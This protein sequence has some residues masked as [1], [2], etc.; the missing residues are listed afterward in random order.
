[1]K[2]NHAQRNRQGITI[3]EVLVCV[4]VVVLLAGMLLPATG[5]CKAKAPRISCVSGLKQIGLAYRMWANDNAGQFPWQVSM[6]ASNPGTE[7]FA[8]TS[9]TW[10]QFQ[11]ISNE[12]NTPKV[13]VCPSDKR[14][15]RVSDWASFTNNSHLSYFVG[16]DASEIFPQSILSGDRNLT[17]SNKAAQGILFLKPG[18]TLGWTKALHEGQGN[19]ALGD[20]SVQQI[21]SGHYASRQL[22]AA[23]QSTT[24]SVIRI[25]LPQ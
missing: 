24:Q 21:N 6:T 11:I 17:V 5:G 22:E 15:T 16:L 19:F 12:L 3:V 20:G 4:V 14:R 1:M 9:E 7:E 25:S 10:R 18:A 23:F 8:L 2:P 13:L